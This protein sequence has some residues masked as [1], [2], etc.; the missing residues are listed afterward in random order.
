MKLGPGE[1]EG[2]TWRAEPFEEFA[3]RLRGRVVAV[4]GRGG[5]G[6]TTL[7]ERISREHPGSVVVHTDDIA[8]W[9]SRFG[10]DDLMAGGVLR[11]WRAGQDVRYQPPA[12][13]PRGRTGY[14][15]V[16]ADAS[17]LIVEGC[18]ASRR[19]L[20]GLIDTA[21]W[22]QSDFDEAKAR[23]LRRDMAQRPDLDEAGALR[24]WDEWMAEEVLFF[25]DDRP[26]RRADFVVRSPVPDGEAVELHLGPVG[27]ALRG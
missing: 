26:W 20:A 24:E 14:V 19:E 13:A 7:A 4:D 10:W 11:P 5:S 25:L 2:G 16:P 27:G 8:W 18:G 15:E 1:P 3:R 23:G 12:W 6:K 22:V 17:L 21:V 9:H